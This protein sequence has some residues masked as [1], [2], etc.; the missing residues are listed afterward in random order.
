[1]VT[2]RNR[3]PQTDWL[4]DGRND[5]TYRLVG[6]TQPNVNHYSAE[7]LQLIDDCVE[8]DPADRPSFTDI[9]DEIYVHVDTAVHPG[10][11]GAGP[12]ANPHSNNL[13]MPGNATFMAVLNAQLAHLP[14]DQYRTGLAFQNLPA[15]TALPQPDLF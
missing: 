4:G 5:R 6:S 9:L 2:L 11:A 3:P 1:M 8:Y 12:P 15:A 7:L 14:Q 10:G 13:R